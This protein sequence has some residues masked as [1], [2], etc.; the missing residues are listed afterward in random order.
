MSL[1]RYCCVNTVTVLLLPSYF[2]LYCYDHCCDTAVLLDLRCCCWCLQLRTPVRLDDSF[3]EELEML[4][5]LLAR[6]ISEVSVVSRLGT[7]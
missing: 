7:V 5:V 4:I 2:S 1:P 6:H 3:L